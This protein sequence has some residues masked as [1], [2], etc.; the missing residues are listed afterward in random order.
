MALRPENVGREYHSLSKFESYEKQLPVFHPFPR[1]PLELRRVIWKLALLGL[2][3]LEPTV[4]YNQIESDSEMCFASPRSSL[5]WTSTL[6]IL[7]RSA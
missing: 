7:C 1:L 4:F 2:R 6:S 3:L 5:A